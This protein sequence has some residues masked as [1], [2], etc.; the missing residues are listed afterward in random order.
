[1]EGEG[2]LLLGAVVDHAGL[3]CPADPPHEGAVAVVGGPGAE[4]GVDGPRGHAD[5]PCGDGSVG[6]VEVGACTRTEGRHI[7]RTARL[8]GILVAAALAA[9]GCTSQDSGASPSDLDLAATCELQH[10]VDAPTIALA[11]PAGWRLDTCGQF[12]P[13]AG[14]DDAATE[15]TSVD[16]TWTVVDEPYDDLTDLS[17]GSPVRDLPTIHEG[18]GSAVA[19]HRA[20]RFVTERSGDDG[21]WP[22][23]TETTQWFVDLDLGAHE[24]DGSR[25]VLVGTAADTEGVAYAAA[26]D[27]LDEMARAIE[28]DDREDLAGV[29]VARAESTRPPWEVVAEGGCLR[30][31]TLGEE[32]EQVDEACDL[33][34]DGLSTVQLDGQALEVPVLAGTAPGVADM[35]GFEDDAHANAVTTGAVPLPDDRTGFAFVHGLRESRT[36]LARTFDGEEVG[37]TTVGPEGVAQPAAADGAGPSTSGGSR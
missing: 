28:I 32:R 12:D 21:P 2:D 1:M 18:M 19:G 24:R 33:D 35:V 37:S 6:T 7:R 10:D 4:Q 23:G 26:V 13:Q 36:L 14:E 17:R 3:L 25:P 5:L 31:Y 29:P 22:E 9:T 20:G 8:V 16:V 34:D 15:G 30:L 27:V 11:H